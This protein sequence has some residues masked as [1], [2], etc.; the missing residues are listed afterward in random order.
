MLSNFHSH[1]SFCDGSN[2]PVDYVREA[3]TQGFLSYGF[4]SHIPLKDHV[5]P[6]NM[7]I[8]SFP[9]YIN[10][11]QNLKYQFA[12]QLN[13][14]VGLETDYNLGLHSNLELK[15]IIDY[16][17]GSIHYVD[18][19]NNNPWE[20]DGLTSVFKTGLLEIFDNNIQN[21]VSRYFT[22]TREMLVNDK[23]DILGHMDKIKMHNLNHPFF[24]ESDTWY[25]NQINQTIE[26]II[27]TDTITEINTRGVY[28]K[29]AAD[30]YPSTW[31]IKRLADAGGKFAISS[32]AHHPSE[33]SKGFED[34]K[35]LLLSIN[36]SEHWILG[37]YGWEPVQI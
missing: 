23:P 7:K 9:T 22:L 32:D 24:L 13:I 5:S 18:F 16:T 31:I 35:K 14:F 15:S 10:T 3:I 25:V 33:I 19:L 6:W 37:K 2:P 4:S 27:Q 11:I 17:V 26:C 21:A 29:Q 1:S 30:F 8:N 12:G 28:K 34:V 20:I 36:V